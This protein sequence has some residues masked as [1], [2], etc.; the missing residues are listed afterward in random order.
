MA[1]TALIIILETLVLGGFWLWDARARRTRRHLRHER[2][3][4]AAT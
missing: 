4:T 1:A 2:P 3:S